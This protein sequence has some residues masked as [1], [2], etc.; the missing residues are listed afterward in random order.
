MKRFQRLLGSLEEEKSRLRLPA[1]SGTK[2]QSGRGYYRRRE[3][4]YDRSSADLRRG[5]RLLNRVQKH[6]EGFPGL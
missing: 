3:A 2:M 1:C 6:S 5:G 4:R